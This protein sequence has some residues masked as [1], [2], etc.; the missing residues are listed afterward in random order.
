[1]W[2]VIVYPLQYR[3]NSTYCCRSKVNIFRKQEINIG[4]KSKYSIAIVRIIWD[5][6][7]ESRL[8]TEYE[9][10]IILKKNSFQNRKNHLWKIRSVWYIWYLDS[11]Q[12]A[13]TGLLGYISPID[14]NLH[15][16]IRV[17]SLLKL[18]LIWDG[19]FLNDQSISSGDD[20]I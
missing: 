12:C 3:M 8:K 10:F 4:I 11:L 13:L 9:N 19:R 5:K 15:F 17:N 18:S 6:F 20:I 1:M 16:A 14:D 7:S 2:T